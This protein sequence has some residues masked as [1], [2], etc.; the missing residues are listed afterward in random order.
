MRE[1]KKD[2]HKL[3]GHDAAFKPAKDLHRRPKAD[4]DHAT[5]LVE[6]KK[7]YR[8]SE[9]AVIIEKPNFLTN[10]PK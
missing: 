6:K 7:N 10:P 4:F 5:D 8:D 1:G 9:G 2:G 3:A